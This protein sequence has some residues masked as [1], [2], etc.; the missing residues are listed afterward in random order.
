MHTINKK[1]GFTPLEKSRSERLKS[2]LLAERSQTG[3]TLVESLIYIGLFAIVI[4]G[5]LLAAYQ[6]VD[7]TRS[8]GTKTT[9]VAEANF[10]FRKFDWAL[11]GSSVTSPS[12]GS[13]DAILE[14]SQG[15]IP[16]VFE[17]NGDGV[18]TIND[19]ELT[20][21]SVLVSDLLFKHIYG[22]GDRPDSL[23]FSFKINGEQFGT[24]TRYIR[25]P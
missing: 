21:D 18:V 3:F 17:L 8:L 14:V 23:E 22:A 5:G 2:H 25:T 9:V 16:Y 15:G 10:L 24:T 11:N 12:P 6:V 19:T 13:E 1:R 20:N 4:G 7:S